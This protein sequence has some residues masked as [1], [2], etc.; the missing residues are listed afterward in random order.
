[1]TTRNILLLAVCTVLLGGPRLAFGGTDQ[2]IQRTIDRLVEKLYE[3][4]NEH[5]LWG[6]EPL[7]EGESPGRHHGGHTALVTYALLMA[8]ESYQDPKLQPAIKFLRRTRMNGTY[9]VSLRNHVWAGLPRKFRSHLIRDSLWLKKAMGAGPARGAYDYT[10]ASEGGR[11]DNSV[12]QYGVLG[13]WEGAK[14]GVRP[15]QSRWKRIE[16]HFIETQHDSGGWTYSGEGKV[17]GSMTAAGLA[18]LYITRG[19]LHRHDFQRVGQTP[20]HP[21]QERIDRGLSWLS[22]NFSPSS[23]P[24]EGNRWLHYYLYGVERVGLASGRK[25]FGEHNWFA[26]GAEFLVRNPGSRPRH[27][28]FSLLFLTRGRAP[29]FANKLRIPGYHWN[30]RPGDLAELTQWASDQ[31]EQRMLWQVVSIDRPAADWLDAPILYLTGHQALQLSEEQAKKL[32]RFIDFGGLLITSADDGREAFTDS[33]ESLL[34]RL[35]PRYRLRTLDSNDELLNTTFQL[36]ENEL[37][38]RSIHN[39]IRHLAL[40]IPRDISWRLHAGSHND[41]FPWKLLTNAYH[42]ATEKTGGRARLDRHVIRPQSGSSADAPE[43]TVGRARYDGNWNPEP[44]S[45]PVQ[46]VF[47]ENAGKL[48]VVPRI[49]E[50]SD[51]PDPEEVPF[52]HVVGTQ[53]VEFTRE[54]VR[55]VQQYTEAGGVILFENAGGRG[56]FTDIVREMLK[57]AYPW[58]QLKPVPLESPLI[59]GEPLGG[60]NLSE[61]DYRRYTLLRLGRVNSP[62]LQAVSIDGQP[63]VLVSDEDLTQALLGQPV[64]GVF[65]YS[66]ESARRL[67]TNIALYA[68]RPTPSAEQEGEASPE[69]AGSAP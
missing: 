45:W 35:Y 30:N 59:R 15:G 1:M 6:D 13:L 31:L 4:R 12:T 18:C 2:Q 48:S 52:V 29:V 47:M 10:Q 32:K 46:A 23:N 68:G 17:T 8:G 19:Y 44:L 34:Q 14:R 5:D 20:D 16:E 56:G 66:T 22:R 43:L 24:G 3:A 36:E 27:M 25:Y 21:L 67:L 42:Y 51:L 39:G 63:R 61:V 26:E 54:Q 33:V 41:P 37:D 55:S 9:A 69:Q 60:Y 58:E 49:V 50:L 64:W 28:A 57:D 65:G 53:A 62:R 7:E 38:V 40:H 11:Y